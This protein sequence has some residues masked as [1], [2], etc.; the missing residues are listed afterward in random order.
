LYWQSLAPVDTD[1][2]VFVHIRNANGEMVAQ[3]D[4]P[5]AAGAYP[6]SLWDSGEIIKDSLIIPLENL[7]PGQ[8]SLVTGLYDARTGE[9]LPVEG[10]PENTIELKVF[11]I[12]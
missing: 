9:R 6:T 12:K 5:P 4:G 11:E 2:T 7:E 8:Y 10:Q 3:K 1:Y